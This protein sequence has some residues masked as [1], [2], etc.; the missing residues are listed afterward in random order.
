M[1]HGVV[2]VS[3]WLRADTIRW[4]DGII[5]STSFTYALD[6]TSTDASYKIFAN[7]TF[8]PWSIAFF[9]TGQSAAFLANVVDR[10]KGAHFVRCIPIGTSDKPRAKVTSDE[11]VLVFRRQGTKDLSHSHLF[12]D[13]PKVT[14]GGVL[15]VAQAYV[16]TQ[17]TIGTIGGGKQVLGKDASAT[18]FFVPYLTNPKEVQVNEELTVHDPLGIR[19]V[20]TGPDPTKKPPKP[21]KKVGGGGDGGG[22]GYC[23]VNSD[24]MYG[25]ESRRSNPQ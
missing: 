12:W 23:V 4:Q 18:R 16:D 21:P 20:S 24:S 25:G 17:M 19:E 6:K 15:V 9:P 10:K 5:T 7:C 22:E 1:G 11:R 3:A 2:R 14:K 8:P 13:V